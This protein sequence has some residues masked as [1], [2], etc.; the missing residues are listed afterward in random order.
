MPEERG[1][2]DHHDHG[3]AARRRQGDGDDNDSVYRHGDE[4]YREYLD[5]NDLD[6]DDLLGAG[7][8]SGRKEVALHLTTR[9]SNEGPPRG[10]LFISGSVIGDW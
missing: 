4:R 2:D 5:D 3:A 10:G 7:H 6:H 8:D 9:C 1:D